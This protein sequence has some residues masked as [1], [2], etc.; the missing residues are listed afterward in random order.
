[1]GCPRA[2]NDGYENRRGNAGDLVAG[3]GFSRE[4][5]T[6]LRRTHGSGFLSLKHAGLGSDRSVRDGAKAA[7]RDREV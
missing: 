5:G 3:T 7:P 1:M 6:D 2:G 4:G